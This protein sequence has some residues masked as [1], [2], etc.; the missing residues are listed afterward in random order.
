MNRQKTTKQDAGV[1]SKHYIYAFR[2]AE[3][4]L[5]L[6]FQEENSD[7]QV[8]RLQTNYRSGQ[9]VLDLANDVIADSEA[10]I[11]LTS[12]TGSA[13]CV[14][15]RQ[16]ASP[17]DEAEV[18]CEEIGSLVTR[19]R[20][21]NTL[22]VLARTGRNLRQL[23]IELRRSKVEYRKYGGQSV[24]DAG[25]V[26]D[27]TSFL[28]LVH[29]PKDR[30]ALMR[31]LMLFP[32][33][34]E[35]QANKAAESTDFF[36]SFPRK[37]SEARHWIEDMKELPFPEAMAYLVEKIEP[38][39]HA[40]YPDNAAE[41][42]VNLH[43][44]AQDCTRGGFTLIDFIDAFVTER[45][46]GPHPE[47]AITLSTIHSAKGLEWE[48]VYILGAGSAQMPSPRTETQEDYKEER[49]LMYVAVTRARTNLLI[50]YPAYYGNVVQGPSPLL[51]SWVE[52]DA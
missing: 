14:Y 7:A 50:S 5:M 51:P 15:A 22:A 10:P 6:R 48:N 28:R 21:A 38:L 32:G 36:G 40:N 49:R 35:V 47:T 46:E 20:K 18:I 12:A 37:A 30:P 4:A 1:K 27:Y 26:K 45:L 2:S 42:M 52:W 34:G 23:E 13:S 11:H 16:F 25:E 17:N 39:I 29:N 41:R 43:N 31:A 33:V 44:L 19:G 24:A 9:E 3:P 8:I